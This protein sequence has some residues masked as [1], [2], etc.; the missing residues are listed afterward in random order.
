MSILIRS[1][2]DEG[3]TL[4]ITKMG[5]DANLFENGYE[6]GL[7]RKIKLAGTIMP[8]LSQIKTD[9]ENVK[10]FGDKASHEAYMPIYKSDVLNIE[11]KF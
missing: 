7:Q 10:W 11:S 6:I 9:M 3:L 5:R 2:L 1:A 4:T 8:K